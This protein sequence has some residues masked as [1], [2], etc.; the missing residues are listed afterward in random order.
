MASETCEPLCAILKR[1]SLSKKTDMKDQDFATGFQKV[2]TAEV[3]VLVKFLE[4]ANNFPSVKDGFEEQLKWLNIQ[5]DHYILDIGSGIGDRAWEMAKM[6]GLSGNVQGIDISETLVSI[7][8]ERYGSSGLPLHFQVADVLEQ[9]F[10]DAS[11]DRIRTERVLLY[12]H[13]LDKA[14]KEIYRVLKQGGK[15]LAFDI[16]WDAFTLV[17]PNKI[18]T[19]KIVA[20][21]S[22]S[23]PNGRIGAYLPLYFKDAGF[24]EIKV[25]PF[26]YLSHLASTKVICSGIL[27]T[28][29]ENGVFTKEEISDWWTEFEKEDAKGIFFVSYN[30]YIVM[31]TK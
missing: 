9:P 14:F 1:Q 12:V 22:D 8:K 4:D 28:G 15:F 26:G 21:I 29:V 27:S 20:F 6:V 3:D 25:K 31:G 10:A 30:G 17:H 11:F 13:D 24:K 16:D 7:S 19:R 23:F 18:L 5:E 2:D